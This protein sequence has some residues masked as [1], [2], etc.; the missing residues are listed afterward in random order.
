MDKSICYLSWPPLAPVWNQKFHN[1]TGT[2]RERIQ[3]IITKQEAHTL[4]LFILAFFQPIAVRFVPSL[5]CHAILCSSYT[6][7]PCMS[8]VS[9]FTS[10]PL[11]LNSD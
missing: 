1:L 7:L 5:Y 2:I 11:I 9:H 4:N 8:V 6:Q 10:F 3:V